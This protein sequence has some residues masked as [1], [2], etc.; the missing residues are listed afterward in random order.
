MERLCISFG[1]VAFVFKSVYFMNVFVKKGE[2][3]MSTAVFEFS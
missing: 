1:L 3:N 2:E